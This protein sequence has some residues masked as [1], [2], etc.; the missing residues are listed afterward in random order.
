MNLSNQTEIKNRAVP[1]HVVHSEDKAVVIS[2]TTGIMCWWASHWSLGEVIVAQAALSSTVWAKILY[3]ITSRDSFIQPFCDTRV[4]SS[5]GDMSER[6]GLSEA[7]HP[8]R[9]DSIAQ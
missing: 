4:T 6:A 3:K 7:I 5:K 2:I 9:G 8:R 1:A